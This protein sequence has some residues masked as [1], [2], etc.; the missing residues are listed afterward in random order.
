VSFTIPNSSCSS[1]SNLTSSSLLAAELADDQEILEFSDS[2][3]LPCSA[4]SPFLELGDID[5]LCGVNKNFKAHF[6][7]AG[8]QLA[9]TLHK[10]ALRSLLSIEKISED[11]TARKRLRNQY[12]DKLVHRFH[13]IATIGAVDWLDFKEK[14]KLAVNA[15]LKDIDDISLQQLAQI[16][17]TNTSKRQVFPLAL[18]RGLSRNTFVDSA[19][20]FA[21]FAE[22]FTSGSRW[23]DEHDHR[24]KEIFIGVYSNLRQKKV[25][26]PEEWAFAV[27]FNTDF[28][29]YG[30]REKVLGEI[31]W[32]IVPALENN[33]TLDLND[34]NA[35]LECGI[36]IS[37]KIS[38]LKE[39]GEH[40]ARIAKLYAQSGRIE[41][42]KTWLGKIQ[43][44]DNPFTFGEAVLAMVKHAVP[45]TLENLVDDAVNYLKRD[46]MQAN[47]LMAPYEKVNYSSAYL[48]EIVKILLN[49]KHINK[50]L[51]VANAIVSPYERNEAIKACEQS[52][53]KNEVETQ[54]ASTTTIPL[55]PILTDSS[56]PL[57]HASPVN[58]AEPQNKPANVSIANTVAPSHST[59]SPQIPIYKSQNELEQPA[60]HASLVASYWNDS[61]V[62]R[63][64]SI[65][66]LGLLPLIVYLWEACCVNRQ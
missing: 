23:F 58:T 42:V 32:S 41:V 25:Y 38:S 18:Y 17:N 2:C 43:V 63:I 20:F 26:R 39:R 44:C 10:L 56:G 47:S 54:D 7:E 37:E 64:F 49:F 12:V 53:I 29:R 52:R 30:K 27:R 3:R 40:Q 65:F 36:K 59:T 45:L 31:C 5:N 11:V 19:D 4:L 66:S 21:E 28:D 62:F 6:L 48:V 33:K 51:F 14:M 55:R 9:Y 22:R 34:R 8:R 35:L 50:A 46:F 13:Q 61:L 57:T 16:A 60:P 24:K 1:S 15:R